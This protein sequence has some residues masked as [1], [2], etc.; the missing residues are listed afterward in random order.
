MKNLSL[1]K[2]RA[3]EKSLGVWVSLTDVYSVETLVRM[4][5]DW[6]CFDLQ[7]GLLSYS[8]LLGLMPIALASNTTPLVR[9]SQNDAGEIGRALDAGAHG[10]IVPMVNSAEEAERAASACRYPLSGGRSFG[11]MRGVLLSGMEYMTTANDEVACIVMIETESGLANVAVIAN[12]PGIDAIFV[13]PMDLCFGLGI[14]PGDFENP[15]FVSALKKI[16]SACNEAGCAAGLFGYSADFARL[17]LE[18]GFTFA[19]AGTDIGFMRDGAQAALSVAGSV[20]KSAKH[21][22]EVE[23]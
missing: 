20:V 3:R 10:V 11:P 9:V 23:Y 1:A 8:H 21:K 18:D 22:S 6:V 14:Q 17:A 12:T 19:S 15:Q 4:G 5:F 7:H 16:K 13:G 2:W